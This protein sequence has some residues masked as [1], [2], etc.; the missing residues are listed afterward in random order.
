MTFHRLDALTT[1]LSKRGERSKI[2]C[3]FPSDELKYLFLM[4]KLNGN[5]YLGAH[6]K[7]SV[8]S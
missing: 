4:W 7:V 3:I 6:V 2:I 5:V 8:Y 1:E